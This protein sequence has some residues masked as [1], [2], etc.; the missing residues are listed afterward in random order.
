MAMDSAGDFVVTWE[1][2]GQDDSGYGIYAQR[3][4][5]NNYNAAFN[6]PVLSG[7]SYNP[8]P[9]PEG[10][11]GVFSFTAHFCND[12]HSAYPLSGLA[13]RTITLTNNNCLLNR[14]YGPTG[15]PSGAV[16]PCGVDSVLDFPATG[17]YSDYALA[18]GECVDV[19]YQIGL[20][21]RKGF[22]FFVDVGGM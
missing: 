8:T 2:N 5:V 11:A 19:T 15:T 20:Q 10:P 12:H 9:V 17:G 6:P 18:V 7:K 16:S 1:S 13:S 3:Y 14:D 4:A 22:S 21:Q